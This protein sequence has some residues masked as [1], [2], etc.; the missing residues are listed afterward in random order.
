MQHSQSKSPGFT[1]KANSERG[2]PE[3]NNLHDTGIRNRNQHWRKGKNRQQL[4]G[5]GTGKVRQQLR[6]TEPRQ[7]ASKPKDTVR[8]EQEKT[9][10]IE[11]W[12]RQHMSKVA[13]SE[14]L[15]GQ[16]LQG[17][18]SWKAESVNCRVRQPRKEQLLLS[19]WP[20]P[21]GSVS[22]EQP[23]AHLQDRNYIVQKLQIFKYV[24]LYIYI[25]THT[26][27]VVAAVVVTKTCLSMWPWLFCIFFPSPSELSKLC[28]RTGMGQ[29]TLSLR[30]LAGP[31]LALRKAL[32]F[33]VIPGLTSPPGPRLGISSNKKRS[34]TYMA[35]KW[36]PSSTVVAIRKLT[37]L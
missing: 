26:S 19:L 6:G 28:L 20:L 15:P 7:E 30:P 17:E 31:I 13:N 12:N 24:Q 35:K 36:R 29:Q 32:K 22:L 11:Q 16:Q 21:Y 18:W 4:T 8:I 2:K 34:K 3:V 5:L 37:R 33:N 9:E 23:N 1:H 27:V 25:Y 10:C 14:V